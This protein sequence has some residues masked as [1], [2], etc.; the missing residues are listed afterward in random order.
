MSAVDDER[1]AEIAAVLRID[2]ITVRRNLGLWVPEPSDTTDI[3]TVDP[4]VLRELLGAIKTALDEDQPL[5]A[6]PR[7]PPSDWDYPDDP[8]RQL[9]HE[10]PYLTVGERVAA[11]H[12][13]NEH[14]DQHDQRE[15]EEEPAEHRRGA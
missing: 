3:P 4:Y 10:N 7:L 14:R 6:V 2:V 5:P 9:I 11:I 8:G 1:A 15:P 13:I 12:A